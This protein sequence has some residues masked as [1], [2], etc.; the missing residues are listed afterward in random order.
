MDEGLTERRG[1]PCNRLLLGCR[2]VPVALS[3]DGL[4]GN[5][6][7]ADL[8]V[9]QP[10]AQICGSWLSVATKQN[11]FCKQFALAARSVTSLLCMVLSASVSVLHP[12]AGHLKPVVAESSHKWFACPTAKRLRHSRQKYFGL[13]D[14]S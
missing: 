5:T 1:P 2:S 11:L 3:A 14:T 10:G 6:A 13:V 12:A 8:S 9:E 7:H 4:R